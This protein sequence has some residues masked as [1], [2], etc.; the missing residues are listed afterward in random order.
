MADA[1]GTMAQVDAIT[2]QASGPVT[3]LPLAGIG[4][5]P[6]AEAGEAVIAACVE[7]LSRL[8]IIE[9]AASRDHDPG[10]KP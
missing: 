10:A 7:F 5:V 1:Y 8:G 6:H 4:H 2:R 3:P 9:S